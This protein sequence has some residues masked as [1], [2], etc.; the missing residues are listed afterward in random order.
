MPAPVPLPGAMVSRGNCRDGAGA[1][2][3]AADAIG[4]HGEGG[5]HVRIADVARLQQVLPDLVN[6]LPPDADDAQVLADA[7]VGAVGG[8]S[9]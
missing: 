3:A 4:A 7:C 1:H 6:L 5:Q 9:G 2:V 8:V